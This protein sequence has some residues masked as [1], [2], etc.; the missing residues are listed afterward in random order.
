MRIIL[1]VLL[2][3]SPLYA[4]TQPFSHAHAHN[5]YEHDHPLFDALHY[6]FTSVEADIY[7]VDGKLLVSHTR[8]IFRARTLDQLYLSPLDSII[9]TNHGKVY[10]GYDGPFYLMIDIKSDGQ[11]VYPVLK[12]ALAH[13][14]ALFHSHNST[15]P[16]II[17]LSGNRPKES[18]LKDRDAPVALDGRPE[19]VGKGYTVAVMPVISDTY[20]KWSTW[21]G[22]GRPAPEALQRI[23]TLAM[24]VH[25]EGKKLRLWAIP[26]NPVAWSE[27]L[28]A[29]VD[30]INT[31]NLKELNQF[32]KAVKK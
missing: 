30:L 27:L 3:L 14:T 9:R 29:G 16:V 20:G 31:D 26:D 24:R 22:I 21:N 10:T 32:L 23:R 2:L 17:F 12:E 1:L 6:G 19:D 8:P 15:G 28:G 11:A 4:S 18:V 5:D 13:Y 7:L 25:A